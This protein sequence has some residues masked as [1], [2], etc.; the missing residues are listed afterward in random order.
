[1]AK[2]YLLEQ[3]DATLALTVYIQPRA[4]RNSL[5]G[6]HGE[7]LKLRITA[8]PVDNRANEAV[9]AFIARLLNI[10]RQ[11]VTL[12]SGHQSRTKRFIIRNI[13]LAEADRLFDLALN[14]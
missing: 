14:D 5:A 9:A 2:P 4:S 11:S 10:P 1:M 3:K 12:K 8:A 6:L 7:A 13:S